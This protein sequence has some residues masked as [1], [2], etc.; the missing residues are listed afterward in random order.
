MARFKYMGE[1]N[2]NAVVSYG[3]TKTINVPLKNGTHLV[4]NAAD[5]TA[6]FTLNTDIGV[7]ITDSRALTCL[8][9]DTRFQEI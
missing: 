9:A 3:P 8:R 6:G 2:R 7:E 5:Q 4:I 1:M